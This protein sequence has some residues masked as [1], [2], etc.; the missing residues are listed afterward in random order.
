LVE[1]LER[2][3]QRYDGELQKEI[4]AFKEAGRS[5]D[6]LELETFRKMVLNGLDP[7]PAVHRSFAETGLPMPRFDLALAAKNSEYLRSL[8]AAGPV[9]MTYLGNQVLPNQERTKKPSP[10]DLNEVL[11]WFPRK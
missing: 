3:R 9:R 8:V 5:D 10:C 1:A 2:V 7:N 11:K 6:A 4:T